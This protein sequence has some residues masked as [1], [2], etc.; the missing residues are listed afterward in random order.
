[1]FEIVQKKSIYNFKYSLNILLV[2]FSGEKKISE[3][4]FYFFKQAC[5]LLLHLPP[6]MNIPRT[7]KIK[8]FINVSLATVTMD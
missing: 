1:M 8:I 2:R 5:F 7:F 4:L 3:I 6:S